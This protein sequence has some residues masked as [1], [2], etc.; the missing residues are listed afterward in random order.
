MEDTPNSAAHLLALCVLCSFQGFKVG[1]YG[2][3]AL[4]KMYRRK[5][6]ADGAMTALN[7]LL[8]QEVRKDSPHSPRVLSSYANY[9]IHEIAS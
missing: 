6:D 3:T 5:R 7:K 9:H 8:Q 2:S 4:L 1:R